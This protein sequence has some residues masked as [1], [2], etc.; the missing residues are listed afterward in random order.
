VAPGYGHDKP[1]KERNVTAKD[2][3]IAK[4]E[5]NERGGRRGGARK[6]RKDAKKDR[7]GSGHRDTEKRDSG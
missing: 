3:K 2:A 5:E 1:S 6:T 4:E 7:E